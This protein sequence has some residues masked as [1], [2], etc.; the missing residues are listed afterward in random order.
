M[1]GVSQFLSWLHSWNREPHLGCGWDCRGLGPEPL[2][3]RP[4][5]VVIIHHDDEPKHATCFVGSCAEE[6][7]YRI[8]PSDPGPGDPGH[9]PGLKRVKAAAQV[10]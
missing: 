5:N 3:P 10:S 7:R 2:T 4:M 6:L 9:V 1:Y 8:S